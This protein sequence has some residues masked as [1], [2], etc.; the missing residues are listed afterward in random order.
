MGEL[1]DLT[2]FFVAAVVNR[3]ATS[4]TGFDDEVVDAFR[5]IWQRSPGLRTDCERKPSRGSSTRC[6]TGGGAPS[7]ARESIGAAT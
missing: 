2:F 5:R 3:D 6:S 7:R 1:F 4:S